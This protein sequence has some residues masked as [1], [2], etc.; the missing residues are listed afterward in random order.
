MSLL[1]SYAKQ[2]KE[3]D[4]HIGLSVVYT[5]SDPSFDLYQEVAP[6]LITKQ[7]LLSEQRRFVQRYAMLE[8]PSSDIPNLAVKSSLFIGRQEELHTLN[9]QYA[10]RTPTTLT[11]ICGEPGIGKTALVNQHIKN[12]YKK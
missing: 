1:F 6:E 8:L 11:V 2:Q 7:Q 10:A 12:H 4:K 5:Y 3:Q 9:K